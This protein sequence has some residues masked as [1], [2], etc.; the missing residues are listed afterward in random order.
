MAIPLSF[1][2]LSLIII[3]LEMTGAPSLKG[4]QRADHL[5]STISIYRPLIYLF[6]DLT[7]STV[8]SMVKRGVRNG[9]ALSSGRVWGREA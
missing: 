9:M 5:R 6:A 4:H 7:T 2:A 1:Q 3:M 8:T